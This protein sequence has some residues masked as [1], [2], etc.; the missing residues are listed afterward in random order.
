MYSGYLQCSKDGVRRTVKVVLVH[1]K[2]GA[3]HYTVDS[4]SSNT[5]VPVDTDGFNIMDVGCKWGS[6]EQDAV[7][8]LAESDRTLI[9]TMDGEATEELVVRDS[10]EW[11]GILRLQKRHGKPPAFLILDGSLALTACQDGD[12]RAGGLFV[13]SVTV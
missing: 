1:T 4:P 3:F 5:N 7:P 13:E 9:P 2:F 11:S 8:V 12:M 6:T 10:M